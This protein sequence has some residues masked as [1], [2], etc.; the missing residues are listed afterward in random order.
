ML[1]QSYRIRAN[2][3]KYG[4][5]LHSRLHHHRMNPLGAI[6]SIDLRLMEHKMTLSFFRRGVM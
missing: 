2:Y 3:I 4:S 6:Y 5:T 1:H